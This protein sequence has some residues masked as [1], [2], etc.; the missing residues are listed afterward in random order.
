[1][2]LV[3]HTPSLINAV[4]ILEFRQQ[5]LSESSELGFRSKDRSLRVIV[6]GLVGFHSA[7]ERRLDFKQMDK[8][9]AFKTPTIRSAPI[10]IL[11]LKWYVISGDML[12]KDKM[13]ICI[14]ENITILV[15]YLI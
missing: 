2:T 5:V 3:P 9:S 14:I 6:M 10:E 8:M 4:S 11:W 1:M 15:V 13:L 7:H 12:R